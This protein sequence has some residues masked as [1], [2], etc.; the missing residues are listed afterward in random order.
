MPM[1]GQDS[2]AP[3]GSILLGYQVNGAAGAFLYAESAALAVVIVK[4]IAMAICNFEDRV[5]RTHAEAVV[6]LEAIAA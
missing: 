6:A 1:F 4:A 5:V 2:I 3:I